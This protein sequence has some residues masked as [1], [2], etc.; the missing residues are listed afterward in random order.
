MDKITVGFDRQGIELDYAGMEFF[1]DTSVEN[2]KQFLGMDKIVQEHMK[3]FAEETKHMEAM[4]P[5]DMTSEDLDLVL[6][7]TKEALRLQH[8]IVL[9]E[10]AFDKVYAKYPNI[11]LCQECFDQLSEDLSEKVQKIVKD[12]ERKRKQKLD[13]YNKHKK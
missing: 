7:K 8:D 3:K 5:E 1:F 2:L 10:G 11:E 9:G 12:K 6:E 4:K 13:K